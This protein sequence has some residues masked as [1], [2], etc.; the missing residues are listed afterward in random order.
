MGYED[1]IAE[2]LAEV[3]QL[4]EQN[5]RLIISSHQN[6]ESVKS[7][8]SMVVMVPCSE[9]SLSVTPVAE[10]A[11]EPAPRW[12]S[13]ESSQGSDRSKGP[14]L[15]VRAQRRQAAYDTTLH[16][17]EEVRE[18]R[19]D[20]VEA[21]QRERQCCVDEWRLNQVKTELQN[22]ARMCRVRERHAGD[23]R[24]EKEELDALLEELEDDVANMRHTL[25][26]ECQKAQALHQQLVSLHAVDHI[27]AQIKKQSG[28]VLKFLDLESK[29][30][31]SSDKQLRR[32]QTIN[33]LQNAVQSYAPALV[34]LVGIAKTA[35]EE[36]FARCKWLDE[37]HRRMCQW[38]QHAVTKGIFVDG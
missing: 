21:K 3:H 5:L 12:R 2:L 32:L 13:D 29:G 15:G 18:L 10:P 14:A 23:L 17:C 11:A 38:L 1:E 26:Q 8:D 31:T 28:S 25:A 22:T 4:K 9:S 34:P 30:L 37:N 27:P 24:K 36:E 6:A 19:I 35:M 7:I 33:R 20:Y 16:L